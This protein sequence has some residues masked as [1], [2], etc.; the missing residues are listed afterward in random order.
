MVHSKYYRSAGLYA[1]QRVL[2]IGN[3]ASGWDI[4]NELA[5]TARRPVYNSRRRR[6]PLEGDEPEPGTAWKPV[7]ARY[8]DDG[9]VEFEDGTALG[10]DEVD[11]VV[12]CTG[13]R[14][15]FP[16]WNAE[17]NGGEIYDYENGKLVGTYWHTFFSAHRTLGIVGI[18]KA[19]TFRSFEYQA[20]ALARLF[21]GRNVLPLPPLR[22]MR[23]W[24]D[25]RLRWVNETGRKYH[26]V[27]SQPGRLGEDTLIWLGFL[28]KMAG[29]GTLKGDGRLPPVLSTEVREALKNIRKYPRRD[30]DEKKLDPDDHDGQKRTANTRGRSEGVKDENEWVLVSRLWA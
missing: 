16:F 18:Q 14:P 7:V 4:T 10:P 8:R 24:E 3:S 11:K 19:L 21:A 12:Y 5:R 27:E 15:S 1:G 26:D 20:V 17:R 29:L 28:Y 30:P 22:E 9:A 6:S 25:D 13:Y 2:T 23:R